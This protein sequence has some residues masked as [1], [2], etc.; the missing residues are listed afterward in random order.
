MFWICE[1]GVMRASRLMNK[2][3]TARKMSI[4]P[5][6]SHIINRTKLIFYHHE[7]IRNIRKL[8]DCKNTNFISF[9]QTFLL[10]FYGTSV[11]LVWI[12]YELCELFVWK[13]T[14]L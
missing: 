8:C 10:F 1:E 11:L 13:K 14:F 12:L 3:K 7:V 9:F 2:F 5:I 6:L 4:V